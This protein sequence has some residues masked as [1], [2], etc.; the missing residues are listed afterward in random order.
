MYRDYSGNIRSINVDYFGS[1][2]E[3]EQPEQQTN[4]G[5]NL[6]PVTTAQDQQ[7]ARLSRLHNY[8]KE[9]QK[10]KQERRYQGNLPRFAPLETAILESVAEL[11]GDGS[12]G[13]PGIHVGR[14][15]EHLGS[16]HAGRMDVPAVEFIDCAINGLVRS[17]RLRLS[18]MSQE[19]MRGLLAGA[20][21]AEGRQSALLQSV[22]LDQ[23]IAP[24]DRFSAE[25]TQRNSGSSNSGSLL[26]SASASTSADEE[27]QRRASRLSSAS[28]SKSKSTTLDS[29]IQSWD[30]VSSPAHY[31]AE[32]GRPQLGERMLTEPTEQRRTS[33]RR[34]SIGRSLSF[35]SK[36]PSSVARDAT[37]HRWSRQ[38][39]A[40]KLRS[41][42][43]DKFKTAEPDSR[44]KPQNRISAN[45][46]SL[47]RS[48]SMRVISSGKGERSVGFARPP[49]EFE[50]RRWQERTAS[51]RRQATIDYLATAQPHKRSFSVR[52][53]SMLAFNSG[54][55]SAGGKIVHF[56]RRLFNLRRLQ[57]EPVPTRLAVR[58]IE[59]HVVGPP[60]G[61]QS[62]L[63]AAGVC[64]AQAPQAAR[65]APKTQVSAPPSSISSSGSSSLIEILDCSP[66]VNSSKRTLRS[67]ERARSL[68]RATWRQVKRPDSSLSQDSEA[69]SSTTKSTVSQQLRRH[70][71]E[72]YKRHRNCTNAREKE[73]I[74]SINVLR[75][76]S[77]HA[78]IQSP[79]SS[80]KTRQSARTSAGKSNA[81][82]TSSSLPTSCGSTTCGTSDRRTQEQSLQTFANDEPSSP[83]SKPDQA[84]LGRDFVALSWALDERQA[85]HYQHQL[86]LIQTDRKRC[87]EAELGQTQTGALLDCENSS[88]E[89]LAGCACA[90]D[91]LRRP[92][93]LESCCL[94]NSYL[95]APV[96][97]ARLCPLAHCPASPLIGLCPLGGPQE[98][99]LQLPIEAGAASPV[100]FCCP[101]WRSMVYNYCQQPLYGGASNP[102]P[103]AASLQQQQQPPAVHQL[104]V[105]AKEGRQTVQI[106]ADQLSRRLENFAASTQQQQQQQHNTTIDL[107]IEIG[108]AGHFNAEQSQ[109]GN[110]RCRLV[111]LPDDSL[112]ESDETEESLSSSHNNQL[113]NKPDGDSFE[114]DSYEDSD[115]ARSDSLRAARAAAAEL[116]AGRLESP[117]QQVA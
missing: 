99:S 2:S 30:P 21:A 92:T 106:G 89:R 40:G 76:A 107:K 5:A 65:L 62:Q 81:E 108:G 11:L 68:S 94:C 82:D 15:V 95:R 16:K 1:T 66:A 14:L 59:R 88:L 105:A 111:Q 31:D 50:G 70:L 63:A 43:R 109:P 56:L 73:F 3:P 117:A 51:E 104:Q 112:D 98:P 85:N 75:Q 23:L 19:A 57:P 49:D 87:H 115:T 101:L 18:A 25:P 8:T 79:R 110:G 78:L 37:D 13:Q 96:P 46:S 60:A 102:I 71:D 86:D 26:Q 41:L 28:T 44:E 29:G 114:R 9:K 61:G 90:L 24:G 72:A 103:A 17:A 33:R 93:E 116:G 27:Q 22:F 91:P 39:A 53:N 4:N 48:K 69:S 6:S 36:K 80:S 52:R 67:E 12:A 83:S 54:N 7:Q 34:F 45:L 58:S 74:D 77:R 32:P 84:G 42:D 10:L 20:S 38:A 35:R 64:Q 97:P 113:A 55:E 47:F 100:D